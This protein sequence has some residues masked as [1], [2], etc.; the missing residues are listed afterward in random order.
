ME[1]AA[2]ASSDG[3]FIDE[4]F[5][6]AKHFYIYLID[7]DGSIRPDGVRAFDLRAGTPESEHLT[8]KAQMLEDVDFVLCAKIG[9]NAVAALER[10][11]TKGYAYSGEIEKVLERYTKRRGLIAN[12]GKAESSYIESCISRGGCSEKGGCSGCG[13]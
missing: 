9:P 10:Y 2:A 3:K 1:R 12:L 11:G 7:D 6:Q 8:A 4:H 13:E 5:G